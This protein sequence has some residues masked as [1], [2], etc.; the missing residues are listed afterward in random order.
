M[1]SQGNTSEMDIY[2]ENFQNIKGELFGRATNTGEDKI[3]IIYEGYYLCVG[4]E[5][6]AINVSNEENLPFQIEE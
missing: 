4:E 1:T 5:K 3:D 2:G 6:E